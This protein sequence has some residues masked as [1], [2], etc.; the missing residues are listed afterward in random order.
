MNLG[1]SNTQSINWKRIK[2]QHVIAAAG[3]AL[4]V[5][6]VIGGVSLRQSNSS[7][8]TPR[9]ASPASIARQAPLPETF[10]YIVGSQAEAAE[11]TSGIANASEEAVDSASRQVFVADSPEADANLVTMLGEL[12][13]A[14]T[15]EN[16]RFVDLRGGAPVPAFDSRPAEYV[17]VV[18]PEAE[19]LSTG[20]NPSW[21]T[22]TADR[23]AYI[24]V[25]TPEAELLSTGMSLP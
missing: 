15:A 20:I 25:V 24:Q 3:V 22:T 13:A 21:Q 17:Q 5:S 11:L 19:L 4:A 14:G 1:I 7:P 12:M 16:V 6:A 9:S 10:V 18:T 2:A 8:A 23:P